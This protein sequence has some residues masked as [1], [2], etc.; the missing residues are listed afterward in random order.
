MESPVSAWAAL[1]ENTPMLP[2]STDPDVS[3]HEVP[4]SEIAT[5]PLVT[6]SS[7]WMS[8]PADISMPQDGAGWSSF[9]RARPLPAIP[10]PNIAFFQNPVGYYPDPGSIQYSPNA[11]VN[12]E[13]QL[14]N[15]ASGSAVGMATLSPQ[16]VF[17]HGLDSP[18]KANMTKP[19]Y[20]TRGRLAQV[21]LILIIT[22]R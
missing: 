11:L 8:C 6:G 14:S 21:P 15:V 19:R 18:E 3:H 9:Q 2:D 1:F 13:A 7:S 5:A 20:A 10:E 17:G 16:H 22:T 4:G 12:Q